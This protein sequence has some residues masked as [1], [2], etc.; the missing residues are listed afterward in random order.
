MP[1]LRVRLT[2]LDRL[3]PQLRDQRGAEYVALLAV[4]S[5][6]DHSRILRFRYS[7][8]A[9]FSHKRSKLNEVLNKKVQSS[10]L[11]SIHQFLSCR[12]FFGLQEM[13][14]NATAPAEDIM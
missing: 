12:F 5:V 10:L 1:T 4:A 9:A 11:F 13:F 2:I 3:H 14:V 6:S 7:Q 8:M